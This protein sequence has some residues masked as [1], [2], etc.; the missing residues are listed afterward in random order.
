MVRKEEAKRDYLPIRKH[1][2]KKVRM[3]SGK[4]YG[5][6]LTAR[7]RNMIHTYIILTNKPSI[8]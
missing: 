3:R 6:K 8:I 5:N 4:I 2:K 1:I 7:K